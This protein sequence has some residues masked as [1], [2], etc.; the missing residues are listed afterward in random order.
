MKQLIDEFEKLHPRIKIEMTELTWSGGHDKI[1]AAFAS[2]R[3]PDVLELGSDWVYEFASRGVLAEVS[4]EAIKIKNDFLGWESCQEGSQIFGFPWMLGSRVIFYNKDLVKN[5]SIRTWDE[6]LTEAKKVHQPERGTYGFGNTKK[7]PHQLYKKVLPFF[8]TNGGDVLSLDKKASVINSPENIE[9]L[10]YY[11]ELCKYGL[12]EN[13]KNLDDKF[14][15]GHI[16]FVFSGGWLIKKIIDQNPGLNYSV[17]MFPKNKNEK[18]PFSFLGG[19]YLVINKQSAKKDSA[20]EFIRF[21]TKKENAL[22]LC[23]ISKVT[24]PAAKSAGNDPYYE[25]KPIESILFEQLRLSR[26]SP[27]H[28]QWVKIEHVIE[29][30]LEYAIYKKKTAKQSLDDAHQRLQTILA[31]P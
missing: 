18:Q 14:V 6:F 10:E 2:G 11:L 8:W 7:E 15:E 24:L 21:L 13:Q 22:K 30:E 31:L 19:E 26:P 1:V 9:A 16:G 5:D 23:S 12:L 20:I 3:A 4:S 17:I 25:D 28:S 27:I 29:D